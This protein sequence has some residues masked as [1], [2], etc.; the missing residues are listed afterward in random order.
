MPGETAHRVDWRS[1]INHMKQVDTI[2]SSSR[3]LMKVCS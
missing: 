1:E 3:G 2:M